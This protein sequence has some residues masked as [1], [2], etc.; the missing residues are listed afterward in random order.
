MHFCEKY[1][2]Y[3]AGFICILSAA[4]LYRPYPTC[5]TGYVF[6]HEAACDCSPVSFT[7]FTVLELVIV[8]IVLGSLALLLSLVHCYR[9]SI[10]FFRHRRG[11][12]V[13]QQ[14]RYRSASFRQK[15]ELLSTRLDRSFQGR[16]PAPP[17]V[18]TVHTATPADTEGEELVRLTSEKKNPPRDVSA[19]HVELD[20]L[21]NH[22]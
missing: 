13:Q 14:Q 21:L 3:A 18:V 16:A 11:R 10:G 2:F 12:S 1:L 4:V 17:A 5:P 6:D 19:S 7:A 9:N 8:V 15:V 20:G 22:K